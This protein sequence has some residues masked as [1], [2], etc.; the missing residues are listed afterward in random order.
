MFI[1]P[2]ETKKYSGIILGVVVMVGV[3][4]WYF[5]SSTR[6]TVFNPSISRPVSSV[7]SGIK[8]G[9]GAMNA[10]GT[11]ELKAGCDRFAGPE[12]TGCEKRVADGE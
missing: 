11:G 1:H 8:N 6:L 2:S 3:L 7:N 5:S 10:T 4:V 9:T 12:K